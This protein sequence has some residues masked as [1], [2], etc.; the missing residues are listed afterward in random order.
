[1]FGLLEVGEKG[2]SGKWDGKYESVMGS[3]QVSFTV[4]VCNVKV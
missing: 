2:A 3:V 1:M 4:F